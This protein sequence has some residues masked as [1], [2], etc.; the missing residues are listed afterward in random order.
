[1]FYGCAISSSVWLTIHELGFVVT[2]AFMGADR[3]H[4]EFPNMI[5][6]AH[7]FLEAT[8]PRQNNSTAT[9]FGAGF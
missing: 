3:E 4:L 5:L 6:T 9:S 2:T 7:D 8:V 1:M